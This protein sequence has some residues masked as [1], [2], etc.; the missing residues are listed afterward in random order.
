MKSFSTFSETRERWIA[1]A[2]YILAH[3]G[4]SVLCPDNEDSEL[5]ITSVDWPDRSHTD[6]YMKCKQC[7]AAN[8]MTYTER[9]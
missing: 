1:A 9:S 5:E 7:G 6:I 8:V 2:E 4:E 3:P